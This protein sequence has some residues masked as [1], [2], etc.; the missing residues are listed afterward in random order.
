MKRAFWITY[1]FFC[2]FFLTLFCSGIVDSQDGLQYLAIARRIYYDHTFEMPD[3]TYPLENIHMSDSVA[4]D[5]KRYSPTGLGFSLALIPSVIIE[6]VMLRLAKTT[7]IESFP[8]QSDWPV[9]FFASLTNA[10]YGGV[11][12]VALAM[13]LN[14]FQISPKKSALLSFF[15]VIC[16]NFFPYTKHIFAHMMFLAFL[17]LTFFLIRKFSLTKNRVYIFLTGVS[18]GAVILSYNP[19]FILTLP[20]VGIYYLLSVRRPFYF[21]WF[22]E[23]AKDIVVG[24]AGLLPFIKLYIWFNQVRFGGALSTGYGSGGIPLIPIPPAYVIFDGGWNLLFSAGK[25]IFLFSPSLLLLIFF[26]HK[27]PIKRLRAELIAFSVLGV[28]FFYFMSTLLGDVDYLL[29]HGDSSWGPRYMLPILP[30]FLLIVGVLITQ[31]SKKQKI[32]IVVP[33]F[34][35]GLWVQI[36]SILLPYQIRFAGLEYD[37]QVNGRYFNIYEY[38]NIIPRYSP[39]FNMSKTLVKRIMYANRI[40]DRGNYNLFLK[41]GFDR[42]FRPNPAEAWREIH[43]SSLITLELPPQETSSL[44]LLISNHPV[45]P[46]SSYSAIIDVLTDQKT[47]ASASI[48]AQTEQWLTFDITPQ[49]SHITEIVLQPTFVATTSA[50][51]PKRQLIFIKDFLIN[52][53]K[54]NLHLIDFP[55]ISDISKNIFNTSYDHYY[56][57]IQK[58]PWTIWHMRSTV[59]EETFDLWWLRPFHYW[60]WPKQFFLTLFF[61]NVLGLSSCGYLLLKKDF[62]QKGKH[63]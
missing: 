7:P 59:Y 36:C 54:Q 13:Y 8:L 45:V 48:S 1:F 51:L 29:W 22:K 42:P 41:D 17:T 37:F 11:L 27:L 62:H 28:I 33:V 12:C 56:G 40:F 52:G 24:L 10:F 6:D 5:G 2:V 46:E 61:L 44:E 4:Q 60:D 50:E 14:T 15:L 55:Y 31:L 16:N 18:F 47:I 49:Q 53:E 23:L 58:D 3:A 21:S 39:V 20:S 26:W 19:I 32:F 43:P 57:S 38:G 25:S 9:M 63:D 34:L 35:I 30:G